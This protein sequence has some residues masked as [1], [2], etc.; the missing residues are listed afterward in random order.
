MSPYSERMLRLIVLLLRDGGPFRVVGRLIWCG[1]RGHHPDP[2]GDGRSGPDLVFGVV[3][4][5]VGGEREEHPPSGEV[6]QRGESGEEEE[7]DGQRAGGEDDE[8]VGQLFGARVHVS[9]HVGDDGGAVPVEE[10]V[11]G[12]GEAL[13]SAGREALE[14]GHAGA[15]PRLADE[16]AVHTA[17]RQTDRQTDRQTERERQRDT[18][19][20]KHRQ[21]TITNTSDTST[22]ASEFSRI[23]TH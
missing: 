3:R 22:I 21:P 18:Q 10:E 11:Q 16:I 8:K 4:G 9:H 17:G 19:R 13:S 12:H 23:N 7:A 5:G 14:E 1:I 15:H 2:L 6:E 20:D